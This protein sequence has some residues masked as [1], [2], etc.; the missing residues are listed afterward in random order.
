MLCSPHL[1]RVFP[2]ASNRV[3]SAVDKLSIGIHAEILECRPDLDLARV[4]K[5]LW[6]YVTISII[7]A[8]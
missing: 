8:G 5:A 1:W 6:L 7:R 3:T 2:H 4:R